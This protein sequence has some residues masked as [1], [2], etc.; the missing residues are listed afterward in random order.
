[1]A[2]TSPN[3]PSLLAR[4][5]LHPAP[6]P[7]P[8]LYSAQARQNSQNRLWSFHQPRQCLS[9]RR[10]TRQSA[11]LPSRRVRP[12]KQKEPAMLHPQNP[13]PIPPNMPSPDNRKTRSPGARRAIPSRLSRLLRAF[14]PS[15]RR[16]SI[17]A[18]PPRP[19]RLRSATPTR[20]R[21]NP[22]ASVASAPQTRGV[23]ATAA[24]ASLCTTAKTPSPHSPGSSAKNKRP[25]VVPAIAADTTLF[26]AFQSTEKSPSAWPDH[27]SLTSRA[28]EHPRNSPRPSPRKPPDFSSH[29]G[30]QPLSAHPRNNSGSRSPC[31]VQTLETSASPPGTRTNQVA[32][33]SQPCARRCQIRIRARW[34]PPRHTFGKRP[35]PPESLLPRFP[36]KSPESP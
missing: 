26:H 15:S 9:P 35:R 21:E 36:D 7:A 17:P 16:Q 2:E 30:R 14:R 4:S 34:R 28:R 23:V 25:R 22:S 33:A 31:L 27:W 5:P 11:H 6:G 20:L 12:A 32:F 29:P 10:A 3:C 8:P 19:A 13:F 1:M 18:S 24:P